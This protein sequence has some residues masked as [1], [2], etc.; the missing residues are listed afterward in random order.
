MC[1][2]RRSQQIL[3]E[4]ANRRRGCS[5]DTDHDLTICRDRSPNVQPFLDL[6]FEDDRRNVHGDEHEVRPPGAPTRDETQQI[7]RLSISEGGIEQILDGPASE[8]GADLAPDRRAVAFVS[9][10]SGRAEVYLAAWPSLSRLRAVSGQGGTSPRW[11][12]DSNELFFWQN[13][14]LMLVPVDR[15]L[16]VGDPRRLFAGAFA[17][18]TGARAFDV[19]ADGR[20]LMVESDPRAELREITVVQNWASPIPRPVN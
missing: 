2:R 20:F 14:T 18:A 17:G 10:Q 7:W 13:E 8:F 3:P 6:I 4:F 15:T 16:G 19:A 9:A 12:R 11:S 1:S 5:H